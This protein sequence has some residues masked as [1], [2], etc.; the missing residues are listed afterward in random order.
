MAA[1]SACRKDVGKLYTSPPRH[2][3][4]GRRVERR[5]DALRDAGLSGFDDS[6]WP[7]VTATDLGAARGGDMVSFLWFRA[8]LTVPPKVMDFDTAVVDPGWGLRRLLSG[9]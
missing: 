9:D 8:T 3:A 4:S 2:R 7:E 1:S 6:A 5:L